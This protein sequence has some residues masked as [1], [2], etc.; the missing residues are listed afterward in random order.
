VV[1]KQQ[2]KECVRE[3]EEGKEMGERVCERGKGRKKRERRETEKG[4]I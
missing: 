2:T 3:R 1:W 4:K